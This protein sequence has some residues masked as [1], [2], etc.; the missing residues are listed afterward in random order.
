MRYHFLWILL[1]VWIAGCS[2]KQQIDEAKTFA[3]CDFRFNEVKD[4]R[5][6]DIDIQDVKKVS[7]LSFK[8]AVRLA[9]ALTGKMIPLTFTLMIEGYNPNPEKAAM[10][11]M[12]WICQI[13]ETEIATGAIEER[14]EINPGETAVVPIAVSSDLK[15][16]FSKKGK[17]TFLN[18][19]FGLIGK[20]HE[21]IL[22]KL[23]IKPTIMIGSWAM[24]YPGYI[25]V[26]KEFTSEDGKK[27][28]KKIKKEMQ[29]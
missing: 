3:K 11:R 19:V 23:K 2:V 14:V 28:R 17:D 26:E 7:D 6:D 27:I 13:D 24:E 1:P 21:P 25:T 12:E 29:D 22:L 10:N 20:D 9:T 15:G 4:L 5:L 16:L 18:M 8:K